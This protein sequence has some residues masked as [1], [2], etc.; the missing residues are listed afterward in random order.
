MA[1]ENLVRD[2]PARLRD[3]VRKAAAREAQG[4]KLRACDKDAIHELA[5]IVWNS[6]RPLLE[7]QS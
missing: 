3:R 5:T 2:V 4:Y 6:N 7:V 1:Y